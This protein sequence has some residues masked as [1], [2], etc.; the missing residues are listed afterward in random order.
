MQKPN[1][2]DGGKV[3]LGGQTPALPVRTLPEN[4]KDTGKVRLGGNCPML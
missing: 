1:I 3:R 2:A 4:S